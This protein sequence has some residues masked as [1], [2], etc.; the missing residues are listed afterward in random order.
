MFNVISF[1]FAFLERKLKSLLPDVIVN[2]PYNRLMIYNVPVSII[3][4]F[5]AIIYYR[6]YYNNYFVN[7]F[8]H[9]DILLNTISGGSWR[10][11]VSART[12][13]YSSTLLYSVN[14]TR[15]LWQWCERVINATFKPMDGYDHC[16]QAYEWALREVLDHTSATE[17]ADVYHGPIWAVYGLAILVT[18]LC[19][20]LLYIPM[21]IAGRLGLFNSRARLLD[22]TYFTRLD[23]KE[24]VPPLWESTIYPPTV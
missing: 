17:R 24:T 19:G 15:P 21:Q 5:F 2:A 22:P 4:L 23:N 13:L 7:L 20:G 16:R 6:K 1:I 11:T 14:S 10:V 12:G 3:R 18:V 8:Y 9:A